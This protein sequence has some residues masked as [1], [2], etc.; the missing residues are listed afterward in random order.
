MFDC[1]PFLTR[2][3]PPNVSFYVDDLEEPWSYAQKFDFIFARVLIGSIS[4][5]PKF[6]K[7]SFE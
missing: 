5:W 7:Q 1:L 3:V 4:D 6:I 2:S